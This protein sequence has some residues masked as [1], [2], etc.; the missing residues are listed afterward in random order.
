MKKV[1][2]ELVDQIASSPNVFLFLDYDGTLTPIVEKP[3]DAALPMAMKE[4]LRR[5][6]ELKGVR[7]A[8][9]S[10][11]SLSDVKKMV[12]LDCGII[13]VGNH[14]LEIEGEG[15]HCNQGDVSHLREL[16]QQILTKLKAKL[17]NVPGV[18]LEDK[19]LGVSF[20]YRMVSPSRYKAVIEDFLEIALAWTADNPFRAVPGK[21]VWEIRPKSF[22]DKGSAAAWL[23][24][25]FASEGDCLP[26]VIGDDVTDEDVFKGLK[27]CGITIKVAEPSEESSSAAYCLCSPDDVEDFLKELI[28]IR[29]KKVAGNVQ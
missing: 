29:E 1:N 21:K 19:G 22:W 24:E 25:H 6:A 12:G 8:I 17:G 23:L 27:D 16:T 15:V 4:T 9:I 7:V 26:V 14:G 3:E 10:G 2:A 20:H 18:L 13:Y 28:K 11:R 5:L